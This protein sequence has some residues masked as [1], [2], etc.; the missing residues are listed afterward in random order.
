MKEVLLTSSVLILAL[1]VLRLAFRKSISRRVQYALWGLVL[2]RLL[3][4]GNLPAMDHSVLTAAEPVIQGLD[5]QSLYLEPVRDHIF[6][7]EGT[8][9][10]SYPWDGTPRPAIAPAS[11]NNI[12]VFTDRYHAVHQREY[13]RQIALTDLLRPVW[14]GGMAIMACWLLWVNLRFRRRLRRARKPYPAEGCPYPVFLVEEGLPSP[15]LFGLLRPAIYLTLEAVQSPEKLRHV[16]AHE[17]THAR[18]LDPLWS[19]LRSLCLTVYWFDPL[20]WIAAIVSKAD[21]ELACDESALARLGEA[22]RIAYGRTLLALIPVRRTSGS[23]LLTATTMTAGKRQLKDRITRI[24]E[25]RRMTGRMLAAAILLAALVCA[26]TFTGAKAA[27]ASPMS[28]G[29]LFYFNQEFFGDSDE[30]RLHRQFLTSLYDTPEDIALRALLDRGTG[31]T[32]MMDGREFHAVTGEDAERLISLNRDTIKISAASFDAFLM[33]YLGLTLA[34]TNGVQLEDLIYSEVYDAYYFFKRPGDTNT[35]PLCIC[36]GEREGDLLHLYYDAAGW[37]LWGE[38]SG[39]ACVTLRSLKT[40]GF[41]FVSNQICEALP[42]PIARPEGEP[43]L[44]ISM[45]TPFTP[46]TVMTDPRPREEL[47]RTLFSVQANEAYSIEFY[48]ADDGLFYAAAVNSMAAEPTLD[49][50]LILPWSLGTDYFDQ[51]VI[52]YPNLFEGHPVVCIPYQAQYMDRGTVICHD[53]YEINEDGQITLLVQLFGDTLKFLDLDGDGVRELIAWDEDGQMLFQKDGRRYVADIPSLLLAYWP[54]LVE[55]DSVQ[56]MD[57]PRC[58]RITGTLRPDLQA[59]EL[60]NAFQAEVYFDRDRLLVYPL[61]YVETRPPEQIRVSLDSA[62]P[63]EP[64]QLEIGQYAGEFGMLLNVGILQDDPPNSVWFWQGDDGK[65]Y[66]SVH[67]LLSS[68]LPLK[69]FMEIPYDAWPERLSAESFQNVCG[70]SGFWVSYPI[71][72]GVQRRAYYYREDGVNFRLADVPDSVYEFDWDGDGWKELLW[73][74]PGDDGIPLLFCRENGLYRMDLYQ[75]L[76]ALWPEASGWQVLDVSD[77]TIVISASSGGD[78]QAHITFDG[79]EL[80]I[81]R[82]LRIL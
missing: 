73:T 46:I 31:L 68:A 72:M 3:A 18:H 49:S 25:N 40:G 61:W 43:L 74:I 33:E 37:L 82:V 10:P 59:P 34:E 8:D 11:Q 42:V 62:V 27:G 44:T 52:F 81:E 12:A 16:L 22:E 36:A 55:L 39:W 5:G 17:E 38:R 80:L 4:P 78:V 9:T 47:V 24:A 2:L 6:P 69:Y 76:S 48:Q 54:E 56:V 60:L 15:C 75:V 70:R 66:A 21:C 41:Q 50:F 13:R 45:D 1:L 58:L 20:V 29:E 28:Q 67:S 65:N 64:E 35:A 77:D 79:G 71:A 30:G 63:Y 57:F 14:Y 19:L 7:P 53:F 23:P 51:N 26:V 32:E